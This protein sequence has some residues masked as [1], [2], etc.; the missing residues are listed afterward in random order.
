MLG[1]L[2]SKHSLVT[3]RIDGWEMESWGMNHR[4]QDLA[5]SPDGQWLAAVDDHCTVHVYWAATR[6]LQ[7][8]LELAARPTS[9][10][11]SEDSRLLLVNKQDGEA[12][13]I[14]LHAATAVRKF[15]GQVGGQYLIRA[16]LGGANE[17]F[18]VSGSDDG[19]IV[20]WHKTM[21]CV[22]ER[23]QAHRPRCNAVAWKPDDPS[24]IASC[25]DDGRVKM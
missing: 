23:L 11:I 21:G 15:L 8:E 16:S 25:G 24:T 5:G 19:S 7:Y 12:Q 20:I 3:Y 14:D 4:V 13:L 10:S 9:V 2:D 17:S 6:E 22:V 18:V 1:T